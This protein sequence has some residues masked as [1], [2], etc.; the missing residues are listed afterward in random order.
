MGSDKDFIEEYKKRLKKAIA[1]EKTN[2]ENAVASLKMSDGQQWDEKERQRRDQ[3]GRP[4]L[5]GNLLEASIM[6]A[7]GDERHNHARVKVRPVNA[8]GDQRL[9]EIRAGI[10]SEVE[11]VSN[12]EAIY[13]YAHEMQCRGAY[14]AWRVLT[15]YCQDNPFVQ[16]IYLERIKNPLTVLMDPDATDA[17]YAD[18]MYGFLLEKMSE[19]EFKEKY[20]GKAAASDPLMS[21]A[22]MSKERSYDKGSVTVAEYYVVEEEKETFCLMS[23]GRVLKKDEADEAVE[24]A[25][26]LS[27]EDEKTSEVPKVYRYVMSDSE[28]I[29]EKAAIPGMLI[30]IVVA[31][32]KEYNVEGEM[33]VKSLVANAI[34]PQKY[35]NYWITAT[36]EVI[37]LAP[38]APYIGTAKQFKGYEGDYAVANVDNLAM[39]KYNVDPD[40]QNTKPTREPAAQVPAAMLAE[41][42]QAEGLVRK[43]IGMGNRDVGEVGPERWGSPSARYRSPGTSAPSPS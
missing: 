23:D 29:E 19:A 24:E 11:Y 13:D 3:K 7:V 21:T 20:P 14:G 25:P 32:G 27:I 31:K 28:I 37:S 26:T 41:V 36:A 6:Q 18:A 39:L 17:Q 22:G 43:A 12:A 10:I 4:V 30:P 38:K 2:R 34:D 33:R 15:R 42:Q 9:A 5:T 16:E 40:A 1:A 8:Q 35:Y